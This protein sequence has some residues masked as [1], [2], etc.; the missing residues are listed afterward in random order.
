MIFKSPNM[1]KQLYNTPKEL[2]RIAY[3][4]EWLSKVFGVECVVTRVTDPVE[5]ES[6]VHPDGRAVDFRDECGGN[7]LY[8]KEDR[9]FIVSF[10]NIKYARKDG[11]KCVIWHS[12]NGAPHHFHIQI[13]V[14]SSQFV[15]ADKLRI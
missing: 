11:K 4:F 13:P 7:Y 12:F 9:E 1:E 15:H 5:G 3:D 6:G 2:K 14:D 10:L 8:S